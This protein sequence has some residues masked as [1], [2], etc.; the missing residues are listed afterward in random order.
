MKD[1]VENAVRALWE[2]SQREAHQVA[3][4]VVRGH[5][6]HQANAVRVALAVLEAASESDYDLRNEAAVRHARTAV[7][8][9][10]AANNGYMPGVPYI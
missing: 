3:A 10:K 8:A 5:R 7:L 9:L 1:T 2:T 4:E 6:T